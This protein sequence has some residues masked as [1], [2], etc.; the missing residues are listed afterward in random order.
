MTYKYLASPYTHSEKA[1]MQSRFEQAEDCLAWL[2]NQSVWTYA[3]IVHCH[4][5]ALKHGLPPNH[6]FWR[7]YDRCMIRASNGVLVLKILDWQTS[8]G[9]K[10][11]IEFA[12]ECGLEVRSIVPD[13][14]VKWRIEF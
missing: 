6:E 13:C 1:V 10:E 3:P 8:R 11:E 7:D 9:V 5:L 12:E 14:T 2:L 4:A